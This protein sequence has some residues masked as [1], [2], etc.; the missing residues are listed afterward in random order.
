MTIPSTKRGANSTSGSA[1]RGRTPKYP[2][3][4]WMR[5]QDVSVKDEW[6]YRSAHRSFLS[7]TDRFVV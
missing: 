2:S 1:Q 3:E 6:F 5:R 7:K 4:S